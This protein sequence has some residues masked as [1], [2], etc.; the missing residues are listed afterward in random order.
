MNNSL[1]IAAT[2][3]QAQQMSIDTIANNLANVSTNGFKK[4][5]VNFQEM[6]HVDGAATSQSPLAAVNPVGLGI[7]I[8]NVSRDFMSG[9]LTQTNSPMDIAINGSGFIE[10]TLAD[11]GR[12]YTRGGTL[13]INQDSYLAT[14]SGQVLKPAI[15]LPQNVSSITIGNDGKVMVQVADQAQ[16]TEVGQIELV[17]FSNPAGLKMVASGVYQPTESSGDATYGKPGAQGFGGI[18]QNVLEGS[19]VSLVDE[20]VTL[21]IAQRAYE[22]SSKIVQASDEIMSLTNNLRR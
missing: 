19:N 7:G 22:M 1:Y 11:G 16:T 14:S 5:R 3:M 8:E 6:L 4:G 20:M 10:V 2:G 21:M 17:N 9:A 12:G 15:H 13:Q 18:A